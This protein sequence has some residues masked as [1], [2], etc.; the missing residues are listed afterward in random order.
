MS[1]Q[2]FYTN[3]SQRDFARL[4]QFQLE[5]HNN[6]DFDTNHTTYIE[7]AS[8]PGRSITNVPVPYMGLAFNVPGTVTYPGSSNYAITFRC[9]ANYNLRSA[10]EA[11]TF[12][13]FD[14]DSSTGDYTIPGSRSVISMNLLGKDMSIVRNYTLFG[15]Y[16]QSLGDTGYDIKDSGTIQTIPAVIAY[17]FWR[18]QNGKNHA[19]PS[20]QV[21][22]TGGSV[23]SP[24]ERSTPVSPWTS[25]GAQTGKNG[26]F[27]F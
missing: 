9:D 2:K 8:L 12:N 10:L 23:K 13:T 27:N 4:F 15:V 21:P 18:A 7:T 11:A 17:Q 6:I 14:E 5:F 24:N 20:S 25:G 16:I 3:A 1:I 19:T 26:R 22:G